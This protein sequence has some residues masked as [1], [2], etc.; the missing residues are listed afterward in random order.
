[1]KVLSRLGQGSY[2]VPSVTVWILCVQLPLCS[3]VCLRAVPV[4]IQRFCVCQPVRLA[5]VSVSACVSVCLRVC[6]Y[7][8]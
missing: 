8:L 7:M 5:G 2:P 1:M 4:F 6:V 3:P